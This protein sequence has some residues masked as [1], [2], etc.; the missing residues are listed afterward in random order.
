[1]FIDGDYSAQHSCMDD[2]PEKIT[3]GSIRHKHDA[4]VLQHINSGITQW[5]PDLH[6]HPRNSFGSDFLSALHKVRK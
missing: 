6:E 4:A 3:A 2:I 1:M 5:V